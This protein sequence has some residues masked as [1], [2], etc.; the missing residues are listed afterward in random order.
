MRL[1]LTAAV[2]S[3]AIATAA[4]NNRVNDDADANMADNAMMANDMN[5]NMAMENDMNMAGNDNM[6]MPMNAAGFVNT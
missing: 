6:A 4:C 1:I 5:S 2:A 3:L